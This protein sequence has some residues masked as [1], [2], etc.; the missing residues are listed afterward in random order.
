M[1]FQ[2]LKEAEDGFHKRIV[3]QAIRKQ[4]PRLVINYGQTADGNYL[5][6]SIQDQQQL[7]EAVASFKDDPFAAMAIVRRNLQNILI[8]ERI[9]D[10]DETRQR[11]ER[12]LR[13]A[14]DL[15]SDLDH[16]IYPPDE[17]TIH[18]GVPTYVPDGFSD[19]GKDKATRTSRRLMRE[20]IRVNK[21]AVFTH[22][23]YL[24]MNVIALCKTET[25]MAK[26][27]ADFIH[28]NVKFRENGKDSFRKSILLHSRIEKGIGVCRHHALLGQTLLQALGIKSQILK[29]FLGGPH[30]CNLLEIDG[31]QYILDITIRKTDG[32]VF[33]EEATVGQVDIG[34]GP[35]VTYSAGTGENNRTYLAHN[36]MFYRIMPND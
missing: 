6:D 23:F 26:M 12:Y 28:Q 4:D 33:L 18:E 20:K 36:E 3:L 31:K 1:E 24:L 13:A 7:D 2:T 21:K 27:I 5:V 30:A 29:C 25:G 10:E 14:L 17:A 9:M 22:T 15:Q 16:E 11:L 35:Q 32:T 34:D 8:D 19:M